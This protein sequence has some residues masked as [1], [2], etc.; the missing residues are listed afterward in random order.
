MFLRTVQYSMAPGQEI[1]AM[2]TF[3]EVEDG[4]DDFNYAA[5]ILSQSIQVSGGNLKY[6]RLM[7]RSHQTFFPSDQERTENRSH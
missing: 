1:S 3:N 6:Y 5:E 4:D 2:N 7:A